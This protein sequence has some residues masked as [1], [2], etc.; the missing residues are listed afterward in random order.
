MKQGLTLLL[1]LCLLLPMPAALAAE[2]EQ[3]PAPVSDLVTKLYDTLSVEEVNQVVATLN[4]ELDE[5]IPELTVGA[6]LD[7]AFNGVSSAGANLG[8][9]L[10][11]LATGELSRNF[12]LLGKLIILAVFCALLQN[13]Q[14]SFEQSGISLLAQSVCF[15]FLAALALHAF[16]HALLFAEQRI[17]SMVSFMEALLPVLISLLT[18]I[19][20]F[21]SAALFSPLMLLVVNVISSIVKD[22]VLPLLLFSS[23]LE[24]INYLSNQYRLIQ[25]AG[26][27]KQAAMVTLGLVLVVFVGMITVQ[28]V[29][30]SVADG[31]SLR[32]AKF[33]A[34]TFIPVVGKMFADTVEVVMGAS[35]LLKNGVGIFGL[36]AIA[37]LCLFPLV[38]LLVLVFAIKLAGALVE[39]LGAE[40]TARCLQTIGT[41]LLLVFGAVLTVTLMFFL[42]ITML[43][44]VGNIGLV[45]H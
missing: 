20:A 28:G 8:P 45:S 38:K 39:P 3:S 15:V 1:L 33:A 12:Q 14:N 7:L 29:V 4:R 10:I 21:S 23:V 31:V 22:V 41:N 19:G 35:L 40:Q 34:S 5:P 32:T 27:L 18:G 44:G 6:V 37:V 42:L 30:G 43:I 25:L 11:R 16:Y 2:A 36:L 26:L 17:D 24:C 13:L 9:M